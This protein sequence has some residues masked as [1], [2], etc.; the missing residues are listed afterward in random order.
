MMRIGGAGLVLVVV[1]FLS[2]CVAPAAKQTL[3]MCR[4]GQ[5]ATHLNVARDGDCQ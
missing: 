2:A 5:D 1:L 3:A 4:G